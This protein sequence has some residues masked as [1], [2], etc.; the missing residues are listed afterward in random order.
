VLSGKV[1]QNTVDRVVAIRA[2]DPR[3][4]GRRDLPAGLA[5]TNSLDDRAFAECPAGSFVSGIQGFKPNGR[6]DIV[7]IRYL[8]RDGVGEQ[9]AVN[10]TDYSVAGGKGSV[11]GLS[12]TISLDN[13]DIA[14]CPPDSFVSGIQGFKPNG[15]HE[16]IQ[17]RYACQN[18]AGQT[19]AVRGTDPTVAGGKGSVSGLAGTFSLD[20]LQSVECPPHSHVSSIQGIRMQ[21]NDALVEIRYA[22]TTPPTP[23]PVVDQNPVLAAQVCGGLGSATAT[24][25]VSLEVNNLGIKGDA[26][27]SLLISRDGVDLGAVGAGAYKNY[28]SC[29]K[30]V[31]GLLA[32]SPPSPAPTHIADTVTYRACSG[33]YESACQAHDVYFYC[34]ADIDSW[35]KARC[36]THSIQR[37]ATY[38]G[39]KCGYAIDQVTCVSPQ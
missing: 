39:N 18:A 30:Q 37:I 6:P 33:E 31:L 4:A 34:G 15:Q 8:C 9:I 36:G 22:C 23:P 24:S 20:N 16:I 7:K 27:N 38:G 21:G 29:I 10:G 2:T 32:S 14:A 28:A 1:A 35:A 3:L 11:A 25:S 19:T 12:G 17:I 13:P 5:G 26:N